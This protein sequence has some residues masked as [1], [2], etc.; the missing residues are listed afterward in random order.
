MLR[1]GLRAGEIAGLLLEDIDWRAGLVRVHGEADRV[2]VLPLPPDVGA[3]VAAYVVEERPSVAGS[4]QVFL[5]SPAPH[6]GLSVPGVSLMVTAALR[7]GGVTG[8][9]AAHRLRH[10]AACGVLAAGGGLIEASQL[11]RHS[12][13]GSAGIYAKADLPAL[14]T[15]ARPWPT[16]EERQ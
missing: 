14:R 4:R 7:R 8:P 11:L 15:L 2:D 16:A 6:A 13:V 9:G 10:T 1:M 3:A 5:R 12:Q